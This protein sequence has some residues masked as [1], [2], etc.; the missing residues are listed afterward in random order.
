MGF[1]YSEVERILEKYKTRDPYELLDAMGA[2]TVISHKYAREGLKGYSIIM[3]RIM[4]AVINGNL[5]RNEMRIAAGHEAGH[6]VIHKDEILASPVRMMKD[7][8]IFD[9]SGRYEREANFFLADFLVSDEDVLGIASNE[10]R[11]FFSAARELCLPAPLYAFKLHSMM[12]RGYDVRSPV[13]LDSGFLGKS[14]EM[15]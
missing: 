1:I 2:V 11:D 8:N 7:F 9:N 6:L 15:W 3:N 14:A 13:D 10:D 5:D 12:K 4:Y